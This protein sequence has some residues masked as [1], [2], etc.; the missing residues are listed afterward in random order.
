MIGLTMVQREAPAAFK[1]ASS[2]SEFIALSVCATATTRA[3][4][5]TIGTIDGMISAATSKKVSA[6][7]PLSVTRSMRASTC[8]VH[9]IASVQMSAARKTANARRMM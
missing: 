1:T 9:T 3:K 8:V 4:G 7:C 6:D 5:T 2:E